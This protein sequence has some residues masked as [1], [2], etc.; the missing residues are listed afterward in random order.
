ME[1]RDE[2]LNKESGTEFR[3]CLNI[4]VNQLF[5]KLCFHKRKES[6]IS[7]QK[8]DHLR[9]SVQKN[10]KLSGKFQNFKIAQTLAISG[11]Y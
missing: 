7:R 1:N 4:E 5:S 3:R 8:H 6:C 2:N 11:P 10:Q 9:V